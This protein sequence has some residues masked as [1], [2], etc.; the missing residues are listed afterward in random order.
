MCGKGTV[1]K[2]GWIAILVTYYKDV[3]VDDAYLIREFDCVA[4]IVFLWHMSSSVED[5]TDRET[6]PSVGIVAM[7]HPWT[8]STSFSRLRRRR[9]RRRRR[10]VAWWWYSEPFVFG[11]AVSVFVACISL[12]DEKRSWFQKNLANV[13]VGAAPIGLFGWSFQCHVN[14]RHE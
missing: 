2:K 5:V 11:D 8:T 7:N 12:H 9:R 10:V 1:H 3:V 6:D 13:C 14:G 4:L